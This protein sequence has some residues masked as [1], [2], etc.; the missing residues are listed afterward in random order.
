MTIQATPAST[1]PTANGHLN[2]ADAT[3]RR[4]AIKEQQSAAAEA[5]KAARR[6]AREQKA[7]AEINGS[8]AQDKIVDHARQQGP[9]RFLPRPWVS[10]G[11]QGLDDAQDSSVSIMTWNV[12]SAAPSSM[13]LRSLMQYHAQITNLL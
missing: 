13:L 3:A 11:I 7:A 8:I 6:L 9:L 2:D 1:A 4:V 12:S 10:A 5:K